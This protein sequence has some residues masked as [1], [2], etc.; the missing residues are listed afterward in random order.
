M[1]GVIRALSL[2]FP[3]TPKISVVGTVASLY[4][5]P[6]LMP[7]LIQ[8]FTH[9]KYL[10]LWWVFVYVAAIFG[11]VVAGSLFNYHSRMRTYLF[12]IRVRSAVTTLVYRKS[13]FVIMGRN[14]TTGMIVNLMSTD[15]LVIMETL[16]NFMVGVLAPVQIAVT[17]GLLSRYIGPYG[18]ISLAVALLAIPIV[19]LMASR[20]GR[21]RARMQSHS[22][23]RLKFIKELLTAIRIVKFYAWE[24]PFLRHIEG[25]REQQLKYVRRIQLLRALLIVMLTNVASFGIGLTFFFYGLNN[26]LTLEKT[27]SA[28]AFLAMLRVPFNYL[29]MLL[30]YLGQ[31]FNSFDRITFFALCSEVSQSRP[32]QSSLNA[33]PRERN[34]SM[35]MT[36]ATFSWETEISI[37]ENRYLELEMQE[38]NMNQRIELAP[39]SD[40]KS[41]LIQKLRSI[42][43]EKAYVHKVVSNLRLT[44]RRRIQQEMKLTGGFASALSRPISPSNSSEHLETAPSAPT[45]FDS[46]ADTGSADDWSGIEDVTPEEKAKYQPLREVSP[47][48]KDINVTIRSGQV[49]AIVGSVGSGKST[50]GLAFLGELHPTSGSVQLASNI[51]YASQEAWI[52]NATVRDNITFGKPY[53]PE[54][55]A[56]V[57][58]ACALVPDLDSFVA[59]DQTE[60]GERGSNLSGGQRQRLNV[61]RA[62]YSK[63]PVVILDDPFSAVDAHVAAH[64][65]EH[66]ALGM[67]A[68]GRTVVLI[69]NQ[70]HFV[71]ETDFIVVLKN[72]RIVEQGSCEL[73]LKVKDGYLRKMLSQQVVHKSANN[74][75]NLLDPD[76]VVSAPTPTRAQSSRNNVNARF[77][78]L[79]A[80]EDALN[81]EKGKMIADEDRKVG[82]IGAG[83]YWSYFKA[84][85]LFMVFLIVLMQILRMACRVSAGIWLSW[86][87]DPTNVRGLSKGVYLGGYLA[88]I[89]GEALFTL[90]GALAFIK[91]ALGAARALH[92]RM[93]VSV[94][95]A[96][97]SWFD[98]TPVGRIISRFSK[99]IDFI[100]IKLPQVVEQATVFI[101]I[102]LAV[103]VSVAVGSP[104]V[105]IILVIAAILFISLILF[106]RPG[107]IQIQR[108]E[109]TSRAPIFS[110]LTE[111]IEGAATIR[112]YRMTEPFKVANMNKIDRNN[113]D[114]IALRY[115]A[116]WYGMAQDWV[117]AFF[118]AASTIVLILVR[119]FAPNSIDVA[120]MIFAL[121]NLG[122]ISA[123]LSD[124]SA[125]ITD[126]EIKMNSA[127]RVLEYCSLPKE[128]PAVIK[129][130]RPPD[131]WP[132]KGAIS[133]DNL[134]I[135]YSESA[136]SA[137]ALKDIC[138]K[139]KPAERVGIVGR[140]GAGKSTLVT[141]L[142]R[143]T[144][145]STGTISIDGVD[146]SKIGLFDLRSRLSIIPQTPQLFVGTIRYNLDPYEEH[147]DH[148]LWLVLKMVRLREHVA[149]L[150]ACLYEM[151]D[152]GGSSFSVGQ[153]QL[154][155]MARCLLK[156]TRVLVLDEATSSVDVET[157]ALLQTMLRNNFRETTVLTI[158]HRLNT[159]MD[160]DRVIVLDKG[161]IVEFDTPK[162]LL[163]ENSIFRSMVDAT[164]PE[165]SAY[166]R[167]I[168]FGEISFI[169]ALSELVGQ[170]NG[171]EESSE[172]MPVPRFRNLARRQQSRLVLGY[173]KVEEDEVIADAKAAARK[174]SSEYLNAKPKRPKLF[175]LGSSKGSSVAVGKK[176]RKPK[177]A[178]KAETIPHAQDDVLE[179]D[180]DP[181]PLL[182]IQP[183]PGS[184]PAHSASLG[185]LP[186]AQ[187]GSSNSMRRATE[188]PRVALPIPSFLASGQRS[189]GESPRPGGMMSL[190]SAREGSS[191][192]SSS[193]IIHHSSAPRPHTARGVSPSE[194]SASFGASH[195][196]RDPPH[197]ENL[198]PRMTSPSPPRRP[199]GSS[200]TSPGKK[201]GTNIRIIGPV[202]PGASSS[203]APAVSGHASD[204]SPPTRNRGIPRPVHHLGGSTGTLPHPSDPSTPPVS[205][206][207]LALASAGGSSP[208]SNPGLLRDTADFSMDPVLASTP[209]PFSPA[210]GAKSPD[211]ASPPT[212]KKT[213]RPSATSSS[214]DRPRVKRT[215]KASSSTSP[216]RRA[217][218]STA[219]GPSTSPGPA[220]RAKGSQAKRTTTASSS[221]SP[222][223]N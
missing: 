111:T 77:I 70:L 193:S 133:F 19:A 134:T 105:I 179:V 165:T 218:A 187:S 35:R 50:L 14:Q 93:T 185:S 212:A 157:D 75:E 37:A 99:D 190:M 201:R 17:L 223:Q 47:N 127:E 56:K 72:G 48:L 158:A 202:P 217:K 94:S 18:L 183:S 115:C 41:E 2:R 109:A 189:P 76:L 219:S 169:E 98:R 10:P 216:A 126:L 222:A 147:S 200:S 122:S 42:L 83:V 69:T 213:R 181:R 196:P 79:T 137:A 144:E 192:R 73:L 44:E 57:I 24:K 87:S 166:L 203:T 121:S 3:R 204:A 7:Y 101:F 25:A 113:V 34:I 27:F 125:T 135:K 171:A 151:I 62:M 153:R 210:L 40:T 60:I 139:I 54:W 104:W 154:L 36:N 123:A 207:L 197:T 85:G 150:P 176:K 180:D 86:W 108:L 31:Y 32:E 106:Y 29:P 49:T 220:R 102:L 143:T 159:I 52:L 12:G 81:R 160:S 152:E 195:L 8:W 162:N 96:K 198:S 97:I 28:M 155:S 23:S 131:E 103:V 119:H 22:D 208:G 1:H 6:L 61:A 172:A 178:S 67:R 161:Q 175:R 140:T 51:A 170:E 100:D 116:S 78:P 132:S 141:A 53:E 88:F 30:A 149:A 65:F 33:Q 5:L 191:M 120:Y 164:G 174:N 43:D 45:R 124:L 20:I 71:P 114:F 177:F 188:I 167:A 209:P 118:V 39:D 38:A 107:S 59:G 184:S 168:A 146:I 163:N 194:S 66:V 130:T 26:T 211:S 138:C 21:L 13:L 129:A 136:D 91:F 74:N 68:A 221:T 182:P 58:Q 55:Y 63:A 173:Y 205:T 112:A 80:E 89:A 46:S 92:E 128:A 15:A 142:F 64:M 9:N 117:G 4:A 16:P 82:N 148:E 95:N 84:G 156:G 206:S 215:A 186:I 11:A 145:P 90:L 214:P 199:P 110:H